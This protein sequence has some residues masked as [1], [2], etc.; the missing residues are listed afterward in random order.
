MPILSPFCT[1]SNW[2][3][4]FKSLIRYGYR[5][6]TEKKEEVIFFYCQSRFSY[7]NTTGSKTEAEAEWQNMAR[8]QHKAGSCY[9]TPKLEGIQS[10]QAFSRGSWLVSSFWGSTYTTNQNFTQLSTPQPKEASSPSCQ[11]EIRKEN[12]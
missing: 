12:V 2:G 10:H 11:F 7:E 8:M 4:Y 5:N 6:G 1:K 9:D 3:H